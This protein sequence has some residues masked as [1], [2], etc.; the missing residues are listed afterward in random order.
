MSLSWRWHRDHNS[1]TQIPR[2]V[3]PNYPTT[4]FRFK[5]CVVF[6]DLCFFFFD[7]VN[8]LNNEQRA[9]PPPPIHT[10][11]QVIWA[12]CIHLAF[13]CAIAS[14]FTAFLCWCLPLP[15]IVVFDVVVW[16]S[17][18]LNATNAKKSSNLCIDRFEAACYQ[19]Q[20]QPTSNQITH[21]CL[22]CHSTLK[23]TNWLAGWLASFPKRLNPL[24]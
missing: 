19:W 22:K 7:F 17:L 15:T 5:F 21:L 2:I 16:S 18:H 23:A 13:L 1:I 12:T 4:L 20:T 24:G 8:R 10:F 11:V 14:H 3:Q 6:S 9:L